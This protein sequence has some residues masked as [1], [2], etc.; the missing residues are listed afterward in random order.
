MI[1][2][3]C[4]LLL[5]TD[6]PALGFLIICTVL[7]IVYNID[8]NMTSLKI[9]NFDRKGKIRLLNYIR[10]PYP[11]QKKFV[12]HVTH[13]KRM[14]LQLS[15]VFSSV[16]ADPTDSNCDATASRH[17]IHEIH[18]WGPGHSACGAHVPYKVVYTCEHFTNFVR[19]I[20]WWIL[21]LLLSS[22]YL[23]AHKLVSARFHGV[24][25]SV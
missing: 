5:K 21:H 16:P 14:D 1:E 6:K 22:T 24:L 10:F 25:F 8:G 13:I 15:G 11:P 7:I 9:G 3:Y 18:E 19:A 23:P 17:G 12:T 4:V 20:Y 2:I